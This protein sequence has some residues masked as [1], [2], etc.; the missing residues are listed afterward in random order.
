MAGLNPQLILAERVRAMAGDWPV[1][2][3]PMFGGITFMLNGNMLCCAGRNG[4]MARVGVESEPQALT[5]AHV[6]RCPGTGRAMPGF[7]LVDHAGLENESD[8]RAWLELAHA[9][10][11][12]LPV[13][14]KKPKRKPTAV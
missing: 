13:K 10:V 1:T 6:Q 9:Y 8:L 12:T 4:L 3:M 14:K 7:L 5:K 11:A 2:E